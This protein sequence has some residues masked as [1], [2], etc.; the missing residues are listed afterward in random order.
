[1]KT[2]LEVLTKIRNKVAKST[3]SQRLFYIIHFFSKFGDK[4]ATLH[5]Y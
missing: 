4:E 3:N 2:R 5:C 1:M